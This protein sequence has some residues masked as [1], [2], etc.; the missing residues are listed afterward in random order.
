MGVEAKGISKKFLKKYKIDECINQFASA[1]GLYST[2]LDINGKMLVEPSGPKTYLGEFYVTVT[3]PKYRKAY[4]DIVSCMADTGE[5]LYSEI[6]DGNPDTRIAVA[7]I[8]VG[9]NFAAAWVLYAHTKSQNHKLFKA[10]DKFS[11]MAK[12]LSV[13]IEGLYK[14]S[15]TITE[16][17]K[18][19]AE[20]EFAKECSD[21]TDEIMDTVGDE[22][23]ESLSIFYEKVGK[24]LNVD[25]IVYYVVDE[26]RPGHMI[27][28]EYWA[29]EG[30]GEKA[31][32]GK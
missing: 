24:L 6:D 30:K 27:L 21:L 7:P 3:N 2:L 23:M 32:M 11:T 31:E 16:D 4:S 29:K 5:S 19:R 1:C 9:G 17:K 26:E 12:S 15:V 20:L 8:F 22:G 25:Y 10:F 14:G 13:M 18:V 28:N